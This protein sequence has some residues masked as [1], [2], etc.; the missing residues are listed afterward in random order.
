MSSILETFIIKITSDASEAKKGNLEAEKSNSQLEQSIKKIDSSSRQASSSVSKL[1]VSLKGAFLRYAGLTAIAYGIKTAA[2]YSDK[3]GKTAKALNINVEELDAWGKAVESAGGKAEDFQRTLQ[4]TKVKLGDLPGLADM[5]SKMSRRDATI[6]GESLGLDQ[7]TITLLYQGRR[8]VEATIARQ[9]ELGVVTKKDAE[10]ASKFNQQWSDTIKVFQ[11]IFR[12]LGAQVL[13]V[14][15]ELLKGGQKLSKFFKEHTNL[16]KALGLALGALI[17]YFF[18][19]SS[20]IFAVGAAFSLAYEDLE[21]FRRGGNSLI[22]E[23][24]KKYPILRD[25]LN[26]LIAANARFWN[27]LK[28]TLEVIDPIFKSV[29]DS[30]DRFIEGFKITIEVVNNLVSALAKLFGFGGKK[31]DVSV[32]TTMNFSKSTERTRVT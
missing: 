23:W 7:G 24:L 11:T 16:A 25:I 15:T 12:S 8:E 22:G 26:D 27:G 21:V 32:N 14:I 9:K 10:I 20:A 29:S 5:L 3:L 2:D 31:V 13:P 4:G 1:G 18:P 28:I 17:A 30:I 19:L 6:F